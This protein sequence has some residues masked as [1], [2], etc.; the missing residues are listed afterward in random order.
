MEGLRGERHGDMDRTPCREESSRY[1]NLN[2][3]SFREKVDIK[4]STGLTTFGVKG[5][6][7]LSLCFMEGVSTQP[8]QSTIL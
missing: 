6:D 4:P 5:E 1:P 8:S 7:T 2:L 3:W